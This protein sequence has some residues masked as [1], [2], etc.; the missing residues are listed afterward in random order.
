MKRNVNVALV[1]SV[2]LDTAMYADIHYCVCNYS[3]LTNR[4]YM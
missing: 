4:L 3:M 2:I 1:S